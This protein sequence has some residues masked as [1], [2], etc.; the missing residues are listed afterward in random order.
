MIA[1]AKQL[2]GRERQRERRYDPRERGEPARE[3]TV[4][5]LAIERLAK[6]RAGLR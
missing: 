3:V 2:E 1:K 4:S 5:D 6:I